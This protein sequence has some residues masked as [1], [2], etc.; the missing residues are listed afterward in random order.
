M[1]FLYNPRWRRSLTC[2]F[3]ITKDNRYSNI[4][5][6]LLLLRNTHFCEVRERG[7]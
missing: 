5:L 6:N 1:D 4:S 3:K 2:V 7:D